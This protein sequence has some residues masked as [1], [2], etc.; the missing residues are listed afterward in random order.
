VLTYSAA[1]K[2]AAT[3]LGSASYSYDANGNM[4]GR[5]ENGIAFTQGWNIENQLVSA[6]TVS[7]TS[8]FVYDGDG[9][10]VKLLDATGITGYIGNLFEV[11]IA[12]TLAAGTGL[13]GYYF[14]NT[15][16]TGSA[17]LT[18]I[19]PTVDFAWGSGSPGAP[20]TTDTF[21]VH[22]NGEV[23]PQFTE[24]YTFYTLSD[25]GIRLWVNGTQVIN[26]WTNHGP[27][28]NSSAGIALTAGQHYSLVLEYYENTGGA[29]SHLYWSSPS[30]PKQVIPQTQLY[31]VDWVVP[32]AT[33][34]TT[35]TP[36][37]TPTPTKTQTPTAT[38]TST[39]T[40]TPTPTNTPLISPTPSNTPTVTQTPTNTATP[41]VTPTP[42]D[43][44]TPTITPT[45]TE[46]ATP[47]P[48][49]IFADGFES[50]DCTAWSSVVDPA[51]CLVDGSAPL[52]DSF[53]A[54]F[55]GAC[56]A[57]SNY[58]VDDSPNREPRYRA[59]FYF[60]PDASMTAFDQSMVIFEA[61]DQT[62]AT[63][64]VQLTLQWTTDHFE[65]VASAW[66]DTAAAYTS[67][68]AIS[69]TTGAHNVEFDWQAAS[70]P[71]ANDGSLS[72][73][74]DG[75]AQ[76]GLSGLDSDGQA[77]DQAHLGLVSQTG[78]AN[79][80]VFDAFESHR[81]S[82]IGPAGGH[83]GHV[84]LLVVG[85]RGGQ[86][87]KNPLRERPLTK[88]VNTAIV[89]AVAT[90]PANQTW[91]LYYYAGMA[92]IAERVLVGSTGNTLYYLHGD[93][94][95]STTAVTCGST[96]TGSACATL[97]ALVT[98]QLYNPWGTIRL[99][100]VMPTNF[101]F[102]GQRL[103]D[104]GLILM[105]A[106][107]YDPF[108]GRWTQPDTIVPGP[109][110]PQ[111]LNRFSYVA[112]NPTRY[113]DPTGHKFCDGEYIDDCGGEGD[114]TPGPGIT[115]PVVTTVDLQPYEILLLQETVYAATSNGTIR[116][117]F[118]NSIS[119]VLINRAI[120]HH[121]VTG[122]IGTTELP[123]LLDAMKIPRPQTE[124]EWAATARLVADRLSRS[125]GSHL[126]GWQA[127]QDAVAA[128]IDETE[129]GNDPTNGS[130]AYTAL[131]RQ[132]KNY[133]NADS[134]RNA[135]W[136]GTT[137][138]PGYYQRVEQYRA[139]A[140][141]HKAFRWSITNQGSVVVLGTGEY[142]TYVAL[143]TANDGCNYTLA[144]G[145]GQ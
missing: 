40:T 55:G 137:S 103:N 82:Y 34:T 120:E 122:I 99:V 6:A 60:A 35:A 61:V 94:L 31:P 136:N 16:L 116:G 128:A 2:H 67:T 62:G 131:T 142:L 118:M 90:P 68:A 125:T 42:T 145:L 110:S 26:N 37:V 10:R 64:P 139:Y 30:T 69:I 57:C 138:L 80:P 21:S 132:Q 36:T 44:A 49:L 140:A 101:G 127:S 46:T 73:W 14:N 25:D 23:V 41:T 115:T 86:L 109:Y 108:L 51:G 124:A 56:P 111:D 13:K 121:S 74:I 89:S 27:T 79:A 28:L 141:S 97:G 112:E 144:C 107:Y 12:R 59:R 45:P 100:G 32:T 114:S 33:P 133:P 104:T 1:H 19:D 71:G 11:H 70:G 126:E 106:R 50:G 72:W 84:Q 53:S 93:Q 38:Q 52:V 17:V 96:G 7:Q 129:H 22:W 65:L 81:V 8:Q 130:T 123:I 76:T 117:S 98:R 20:V 48:D 9:N 91:T 66:D 5:T 87:G 92:R 83:S 29:D 135:F 39:P 54:S 15:S 18:R 3:G 105:G 78:D 102:T 24:T 4:T 43:T 85:P 119:H 95:G 88:G 58:L 143:I 63:T 113:T 134:L 47:L 75:T 77:I